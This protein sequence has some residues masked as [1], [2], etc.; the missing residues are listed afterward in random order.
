MNALSE[1][2]ICSNANYLR[3]P[4]KSNT[5]NAFKQDS[6]ISIC[7]AFQLEKQR[8]TKHR[9]VFEAKQLLY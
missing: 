8:F 5:L 4:C 1:S 6:K 3:F 7:F 2:M 9:P